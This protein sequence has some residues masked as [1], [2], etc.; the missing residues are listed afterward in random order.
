MVQANNPRPKT[1]VTL[2]FLFRGIC[3]RQIRGS[4]SINTEKSEITL[5]TP[6]VTPSIFALSNVQE[7]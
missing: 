5:R 7:S 3:N 1:A 6:E 2:I 4:G